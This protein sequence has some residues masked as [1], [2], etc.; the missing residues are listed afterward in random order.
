M[1][2]DVYRNDDV[3]TYLDS[4]FVLVKLNAESPS[5]LTFKGKHYTETSLA[6]YL[7][8]TSYP[9]TVFAETDGTLITPVAGYIEARSFLDVC[10]F[11][12]DGFYKKMSW[13]EYQDNKGNQEKERNSEKK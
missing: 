5:S 8:I 7:G 2:Q 10:K 6:S 13:K 9:T 12:G 3:A 11:F 4:Q 1:D